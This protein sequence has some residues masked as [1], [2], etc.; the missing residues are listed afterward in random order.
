MYGSANSGKNYVC[1][2]VLPWLFRNKG[3]LLTR[4]A[5]WLFAF[6]LLTY[7]YGTAFDSFELGFAVIGMLLPVHICYYYLITNVVL[8]RYFKEKY[9]SS[10]LFT[11]CIMAAMA[12]VYRLAEIYITDPYIFRYYIR[13]NP[14]F[15]WPKLDKSPWQQLINQGDFVNAVERSNVVVWIG[16]TLKLFAMWHER[17][18]AILQAELNLLKGQIHPHFLFNSL[19]N[20]YALSLNNAPQAPGI[21]LGLSNI[22]RYV[23]YECTA[24]QVLLERDI[25]VLKDYIRLEQLRYEERLDL[26]VNIDVEP[27]PWQI[28]PILML[29]LVENAFKHGAGET[30][31]N[32]WINIE[33]QVSRAELLLK[34]SNS[35][36]EPASSAGDKQ[37][38]GIGLNNV[39]H[40]LKLLYPDAHSLQW[41]NEE[42]CFIIEMK[43]KL[44]HLH[45]S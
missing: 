24:D 6:V 8:P 27:G 29:P 12:V 16:I 5:F 41:Y 2:M 40:R 3:R 37:N 34:I 26:N 11:I 20:L 33:L 35:K 25:E 31:H 21:I 14:A 17:K 18:N 36:P 39:R 43:V 7:I 13:Q 23:I 4:L 15:T 32:P 1:I 42:D 9:L 38:G 30:M 19:N 44:T 28:A 45:K 22:L 10:A